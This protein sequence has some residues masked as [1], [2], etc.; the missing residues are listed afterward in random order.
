MRLSLFSP[1][2]SVSLALICALANVASAQTSPKITSWYTAKSGKYARL[3][4]TDA[5]LS[6]DTTKTTW[7]RT[8]GPNTTTQASPVY[9]GPQ[10]IDY[11]SS[12]VYVKTPDLGTYTM[13]PW[14]DNA[15]RTALFV[16]IPKNQGI[17]FRIPL[18][19]TIPSTKTGTQGLN[20]GGVMQDAI[21]YCVDGVAIFD[22]L[23]G[24]TYS[25]TSEAQG[26]NGQWHR[27]A[28]VNEGITFDKSMAHQQNTG[29]YHNH[30]N[31]IALRYQLGD[32]VTFNST[33]KAYS[34]GN[35][36]A[37]T[38]HSPIIG[39]M[40]DGL[41][42]YGPYG[43]SSAMDATS[44]VRRM[45]GGFVPRNGATTGVDNISTAGRT[46]P[47]WTIRNNGGVTA[48]GP[49]V[50]TT[51]PLGRYIE[52]WAYLGD[53]NKVGTTKYAIGT[54]FDLNEYNVR[55]CV[56]PE[57][58]GGTY[59]Y[60]LNISS[61]G[62]PQFPYMVNRWFYGAP[63]GGALTTV[64]DTVTNYFMG[65][66]NR[67]LNITNTSVSGSNV[68]L[69]WDAVEGGTYSVEASSNNTTFTSKATGLT[70]TNANTKSNTHTALGSSGAE[71]ARV[72]RTALAT[73]DSTGTTA[74][75]VA[76]TATT[77]FTF[78]TTPT[79]TTISTLTSATENTAFT[80]SY[81]A[82]AA[83]AD[84]ADGDGNTVSFRVEAISS[85][86]LT[87]NGVSVTAGTTL[88]STGE[89]LV[90]TPATNANGTLAA[91][92]IKA[93]D[94]TV[95]SSTAVAVNVTVTAVSNV[96]VWDG[97]A[98]TSAWGTAANWLGDVV[99]DSIDGVSF[100]GSIPYGVVLGANRSVA[101]VAFSGNS[102]YTLSGNTL[103]LA[104]G[105]VISTTAPG[106]G[107]VTHVISSALVLS[108]ITGF[109]IAANANLTLSGGVSGTAALTKSGGGTLTISSAHTRVG[110][111][112]VTGGTLSLS[113]A[114]LSDAGDV[115]LV[116]GGTLNLNF[117]G[118]DTIHSFYL[119]GVLSR[120]GTWGAVGSSAINQDSRITG[121]GILY[122]T[123]GLPTFENWAT[124]LGLTGNN[125]LS[126]ADPDNDG[127]QNRLEFVLGGNPSNGDSTTVL[128]TF[129]VV[130]NFMFF[131]FTRNDDS[132]TDTAVKLQYS[133]DLSAWI[134]VPVGSVSSVGDGASVLVFEN[135]TAAD[136]IT[137]QIQ[138]GTKTKLFAR[139]AVEAR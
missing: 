104:S 9:A 125:A 23:D 93:W 76:Q 45:V 88:L 138:L 64:T 132:E 60:F 91:F 87:K 40:L 116:T 12:W 30:A 137:A 103:S 99:P 128:P 63:T 37:P 41:P 135:G 114:S 69:T 3:V 43:Y 14:Y 82:L 98:A 25:G 71:Y 130:G 8:A 48:S 44:G 131:S 97:G 65:G 133:S 51:Y 18:T 24:Y 52:D 127:I 46:L 13:G 109:S 113:S 86:T 124:L 134:D 33:T 38:A 100:T 58:P 120:T 75:T 85:G 84:E 111:T 102:A 68:S 108:E 89:S 117:S 112:S 119:N 77:S 72:K 70:V 5:E 4:E 50:S 57:F 79:L 110:G 32:N 123:S 31:P 42:V 54:D 35:T 11:T 22:P 17:T 66:A 92:T 39:W 121:T 73:Y 118:T 47:A 122:V 49:A 7:T 126:S 95:A 96:A 106:S 139:L 26:G 78:N 36:A 56:T 115:S 55:L 20:V 61:T 94:G 136:G 74:A 15:A 83:A 107:T 16:N 19:S 34:E 29:K 101:S 90:W 129:A 10:Q 105:G 1:I 6:A 67:P 28:Y 27:D 53:L 59:A 81:A 21:G 80:I 62:S 2:V